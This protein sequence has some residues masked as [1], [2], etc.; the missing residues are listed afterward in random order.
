MSFARNRLPDAL[1]YFEGEG[2][3]LVG[4][5][6]WRTAMCEFHGGSDSLRVNT[7]T[8]GWICMACGEKA[9]DVLGYHMAKYGLEFVEAC[10]ALG[11]WDDDGKP[12]QSK[13]S[14]F[15]ARSALQVLRFDSLVVAVA[16]CGLA[17]G[18]PLSDEDRKRLVQA[19]STIEFIAAE[20]SR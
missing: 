14:S 18:K 7:Q 2:L 6:L 12:G 4:R 19:A 9:G 20:A 3:A 8:G 17:S 5:G 13:P 16:A 11:A 1:T 15:S 10:Q